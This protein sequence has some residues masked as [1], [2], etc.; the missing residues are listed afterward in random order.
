MRDHDL[1]KHGCAVVSYD[2]DLGAVKGQVKCVN[3]IARDHPDP[4]VRPRPP[5]L[6]GPGR[7]DV[8][9]A[10]IRPNPPTVRSLRG[11]LQGVCVGFA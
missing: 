7:Y 1:A 4:V 6:T 9:L 3:N 5:L 2:V 11:P 8:N 10:G